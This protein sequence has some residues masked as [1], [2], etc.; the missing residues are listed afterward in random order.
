MAKKSSDLQ[1]NA[2][3]IGATVSNPLPGQQVPNATT[4]A[5]NQQ[6]AEQAEQAT[7]INPFMALTPEQFKQ[8]ADLFAA[9]L[10]AHQQAER[11]AAAAAARAAI[12]AEHEKNMQQ[13]K[14]AIAEQCATFAATL[15]SV[16]NATLTDVKAMLTDFIKALPNVPQLPAEKLAAKVKKQGGEF[17]AG[18]GT[19]A[20]GRSTGVSPK[21][22]V[23]EFVALH[24]QC[25]Q[26]ELLEYL[27]QQRPDYNSKANLRNSMLRALGQLGLILQAKAS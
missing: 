10:L 7:V 19:D 25:T 27:Q 1:P 24:P 20:T 22:L 26:A 4:V 9:A 15:G 23:G 21:V 3:G 11:E 18:T 12:V 5:S 17:K 8:Q 2:N 13:H 16:T 6:Q 14:A